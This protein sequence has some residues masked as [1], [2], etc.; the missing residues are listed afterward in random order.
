MRYIL[1]PLI[2]IPAIE[3]VVLLLAGKALGVA[4]TFLLIILT[5]VF[6]VYIAKRQGIEVMKKVQ[7]ETRRGEMPGDSMLDGVCIFIAGIFLVLPGFISDFIGILLLIP[8]IRNKLKIIL[9]HF[10]RRRINHGN[11]KV[12]KW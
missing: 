10:L 12:I 6:G 11:I 2:L 5:G 9:Y 1:L 8:F 4:V 7:M 3:I